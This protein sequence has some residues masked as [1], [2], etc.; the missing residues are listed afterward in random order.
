M[1][2][3]KKRFFPS[4]FLILIVLLLVSFNLDFVK[5]NVD[6]I[7]SFISHNFSWLFIGANIAAFIF[8]LWIIFRHYKFRKNKFSI[9]TMCKKCMSITKKTPRHFHGVFCTYH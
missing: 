1:N 5:A 7:Y 6:K 4:V 8:S 3:D 9:R 2:I